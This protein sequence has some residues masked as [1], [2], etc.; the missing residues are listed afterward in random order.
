VS[1]TVC[2]DVKL[3]GSGTGRL[4]PCGNEI[5]PLSEEH[6]ELFV[7]LDRLLT[8]GS[9][10]TPEHPRYQDVAAGAHA[11][12]T[13][14]MVGG[15]K[16]EIEC[17]SEGFWVHNV[18]I[19]GDQNETHRVY[20]L[21][22]TLNLALL[23][24]HSGVSTKDLHEAVTIL[25]NFQVTQAGKKTY[26]E[27]QIT[28]LPYT[29]EVTSQSL[30]VKTRGGISGRG[31]ARTG[32]ADNYIIPDANLVPTPDGQKL[33]RKFLSIVSGIMANGDPTKLGD[34][35]DEGV[36]DQLLSDWVPDSAVNSIKEIMAALKRTNTDPM[37]MEHLIGY[38]QAAL[39]LT[40]DPFLVELIFQRLRK[41]TGLKTQKSK[42]L[43]ENRPKPKNPTKGPVKY[44]MTPD[45]MNEA[46][47]ELTAAS[48][49][50]EDL[51][52]PST[53]DCLGI[54]TQI[55]CSAPTE[56]MIQGIGTTVFRIL[57]EDNLT[58][59]DLAVIRGSI[60][61]ILKTGSREIID[62]ALPLFLTPLRNFHPRFVGPLWLEAWKSLREIDN[63]RLAWPHLVNELL[64]GIEWDDPGAKLAL[65]E[66]L[67]RIDVGDG[68][69]MLERLEEMKALKSKKISPEFFHA[70]APLLY[71]VHLVL[72]DS[73]VF[74][75]HGPKMFG[76]L[77]H[78]R[79]QRL[80][81]LLIIIMGEYRHSNKL[82]FQAILDQGVD[83]KIKPKL[84]DIGS[85]ML[86]N[87]IRNLEP[88]SRED[89]WVVDAI[90][91]LGRLDPKRAQTVLTRILTEKRFFL[92][93]VWPAECRE[94]VR[95]ALATKQ[96]HFQR[97]DPV[98]T[99]EIEPEDER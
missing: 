1:K 72:L 61:A 9:Y 62:G 87:T 37:I 45:Q 56:H 40:A 93:P 70:P 95:R 13:K 97:E 94:A 32:L 14:N 92:F 41:E 59:Q 22:T 88:E 2:S 52:A 99:D 42:S 8:I 84:E 71:S 3:P 78:Q 74:K 27:V 47:A 50:P 66:S 58:E 12:L 44:T 7:A 96:D 75:D 24:I 11:A 60:S 43:L 34:A 5:Q 28:G 86:A 18:Y 38:A 51:L 79:A 65:Y 77:F 17:S 76:R 30:Y 10:Y 33:E 26:E 90:T 39:E 23:E 49:V 31:R 25:K 55:L 29:I 4:D 67:S 69:A 64:L 20:E 81:N 16:L 19:E 85:R 46:I 36:N 82:I 80:S 68:K 57:S 15:V 6:T 53:A 83:E 73:S 98:T 89:L 48:E 54:C 35:D 63:Q 91:W 21:M